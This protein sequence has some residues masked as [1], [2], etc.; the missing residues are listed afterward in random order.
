MLFGSGQLQPWAAET[1]EQTVDGKELHEYLTRDNRYNTAKEI[2]G[3]S[4]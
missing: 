2:K 3:E 1:C 4:A